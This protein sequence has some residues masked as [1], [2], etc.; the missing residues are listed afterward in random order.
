MSGLDWFKS[1]HGAP[2]DLKWLSVARKADAPVSVVIALAWALMDHASQAKNRGDISGFNL[3]EFAAYLGETD[4]TLHRVTETLCN[5][6]WLSDGR[7]SRWE[8]RQEQSKGES[9][10]RV[11]RHRA[12]K[13]QGA[14]T[15]ENPTKAKRDE[16]ANVTPLP[17]SQRYVTLRNGQDRDRDRDRSIQLAEA[18][19]PYRATTALPATALDVQHREKPRARASP[20]GG[21]Q[22]RGRAA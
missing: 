1:W 20:D 5:I 18:V 3:E 11:Q 17:V 15:P 2:T 12:K 13:R 22:R 7:I 10:A 8:E 6:G 16:T 21:P 14:Q 4:E 9:T 19:V